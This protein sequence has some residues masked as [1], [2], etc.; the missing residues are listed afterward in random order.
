MNLARYKYERKQTRKEYLFYSEGEK[1]RIGF[2]VA[3]KNVVIKDYVTLE[4]PTESYM[5]ASQKKVP[6][7]EYIYDDRTVD[8]PELANIETDPAVLRKR[9]AARKQFEKMPITEDFLK[10]FNLL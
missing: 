10:K 1:G 7:E 5:T 4:E 3:H 8:E 9:E 2:L 6:K